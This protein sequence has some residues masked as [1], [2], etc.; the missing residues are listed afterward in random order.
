MGLNSTISFFFFFFHFPWKGK[1]TTNIHK[2]F[3]NTSSKTISVVLH[4]MLLICVRGFDCCVAFR[5]M[6]F[7]CIRRSYYYK[8]KRIVMKL[9]YINE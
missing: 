3:S 5:F 7:I 6:L 4:F 8:E 1:M 9:S 2:L